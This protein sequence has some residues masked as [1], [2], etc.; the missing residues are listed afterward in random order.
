MARAFP[1]SARRGFR[2]PAALQRQPE[3]WGIPLRATGST[4][5]V[6][7]SS[8][9]AIE[10]SVSPR[11]LTLSAMSSALRP[12]PGGAVSEMAEALS[13]SPEPGARRHRG[14]PCPRR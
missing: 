9:S 5:R 14:A 11:S 8:P 7:P 4:P 10:V 1:E 2:G 3:D 13:D 12:D 6:S